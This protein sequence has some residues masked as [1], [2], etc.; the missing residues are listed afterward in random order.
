[1]MLFACFRDANIKISE[2]ENILQFINDTLQNGHLRTK[3]IELFELYTK[4]TVRA[5]LRCI[6][7][8]R[9][10]KLYFM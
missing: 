7:Y 5:R 8:G 2:T 4:Q 1:M 3:E 10:V 6:K 9:I